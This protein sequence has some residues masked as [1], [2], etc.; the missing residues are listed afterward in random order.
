MASVDLRVAGLCF[1][2]DLQDEQDHFIL[3]VFFMNWTVIFG[4]DHGPRNQDSVSRRRRRARI[5][6]DDSQS[7]LQIPLVD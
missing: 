3:C 1:G 5:L 4:E 6:L 2:R 7:H